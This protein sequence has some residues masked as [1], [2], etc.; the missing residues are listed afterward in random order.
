[1][2]PQVK[3]EEMSR[4]ESSEVAIF[5]KPRLPYHPGLEKRFGITITQWRTLTDIIYR[6]AISHES[7]VLALGYC[8]TRNL[9]IMKR[10]VHIVP[11]WDSKK[12]GYVETIWQGISEL[13]TT[14]FRTGN[15]AGSDEAEF[16]PF[17]EKTF[18]GKIKK[19]KE[20]V[21]REITMQFPEWCRVTVYRDL[22]GRLCK[23]VGPK[24]V[25]LEAYATIGRSDLPNDMWENRPEGQIE[26]C[27]EAAALRKA[28]PEEIG[29]ELT[30]DE[31]AGRILTEAA[32]ERTVSSPTAVA[33][34][35]APPDHSTVKGG[36]GQQPK[37]VAAATAPDEIVVEEEDGL[38]L[39]EPAQETT[40]T[41][42]KPV[43]QPGQDGFTAD[44]I[45][46]IKDVTGAFSTCEDLEAFGKKQR[47]IMAPRKNSVSKQAWT[48]AQ[49][50]AEDTYRRI[51]NAE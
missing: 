21:A 11:M 29:N 6:G 10:P 30:S 34:E 31:M 43:Q 26:K 7:I 5:Q 47:E 23:F 38:P 33:V 40:A 4:E 35:E 3:P 13:R 49:H 19:D 44:E 15:Y 25:W 8:K 32:R 36:N 42:A 12:G 9:D 20:W 17:V 1:M 46:W 18:K 16:G 37:P 45:Q 39:E 27:A 2:D 50:A 51:S 41:T 22:H 14:A 28:F 48:K 24:V